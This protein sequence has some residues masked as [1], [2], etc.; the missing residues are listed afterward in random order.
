VAAEAARAAIIPARARF[1]VFSIV[2]TSPGRA[3]VRWI[4]HRR[5][6]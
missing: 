6:S 4:V 5:R 1:I 3:L 2:R